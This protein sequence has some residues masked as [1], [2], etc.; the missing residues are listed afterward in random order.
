VS[1]ALNTYRKKIWSTI[2][3]KMA[4]KRAMQ[5][6]HNNQSAE[7]VSRLSAPTAPLEE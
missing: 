2:V 6:L 3:A 1:G 5:T 7:A 4:M